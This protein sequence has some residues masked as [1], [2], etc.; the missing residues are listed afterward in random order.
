MP[1]SG[2]ASIHFAGTVASTPGTYF[3]NASG[4]AEGFTVAPTGDTAPV[5]VAA[6]RDERL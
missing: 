6:G 1:A 3:N 2:D 4:V 5:T